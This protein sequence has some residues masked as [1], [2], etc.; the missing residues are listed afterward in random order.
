MIN[1]LISIIVVNVL[2]I[3]EERFVVPVYK[4]LVPVYKT[5]AGVELAVFFLN[6]LAQ[7]FRS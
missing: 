5:H 6:R 7:A 1:T 4:P 2:I 3:I